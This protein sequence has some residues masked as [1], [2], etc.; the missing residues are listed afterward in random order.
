MSQHQ[1]VFES[2]YLGTEDRIDA[3]KNKW[4]SLTMAENGHLFDL[5]HIMHNMNAMKLSNREC[6]SLSID[7]EKE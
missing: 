5:H 7:S 4:N 3:L 2:T 1:G 6:I